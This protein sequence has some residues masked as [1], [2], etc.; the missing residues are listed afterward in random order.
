MTWEGSSGL[1]VSAKV[2]DVGEV[3][4]CEWPFVRL[5]EARRKDGGGETGLPSSMSF[6]STMILS[7]SFGLGFFFASFSR[8][9]GVEGVPISVGVDFASVLC[10]DVKG[11]VP[12]GAS[13]I[14]V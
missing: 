1:G 13:C 6:S 9:A 5:G 14:Y 11:D 2:G 3:G 7:L 8:L 4:E 12:D 10:G